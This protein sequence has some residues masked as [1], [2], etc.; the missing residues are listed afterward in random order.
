[1]ASAVRTASRARLAVGPVDRGRLQPR[2]V[3]AVAESG[4]TTGG[5][6]GCGAEDGWRRPGRTALGQ[7][8]LHHG[9]SQPGAAAWC[10]PAGRGAPEPEHASISSPVETWAPPRRSRSARRTIRSKS[11]LG[12]PVTAVMVV[13]CGAE[14][15]CGMRTHAWTKRSRTWV[16]PGTTRTAGESSMVA[17]V[18]RRQ[19]TSSASA[20]SSGDGPVGASRLAR[21]CDLAGVDVLWAPT[22]ATRS[23][24]ARRSTGPR[25]WCG[26]RWTSRGLGRCR[27]RS[28]GRRRRP[29]PGPTSTPGLAD[30]GDLVGDGC[31]A[32]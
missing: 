23:S 1:M 21:M 24:W 2:R 15:S 3:R 28:A 30:F 27:C 25:C 26:P 31:S 4:R 5:L 32:R 10:G 6:L 16:R 13:G 14:Q 8:L 18:P 22:S 29:T 9:R 11:G 17:A 20:W 7:G 19:D 12:P